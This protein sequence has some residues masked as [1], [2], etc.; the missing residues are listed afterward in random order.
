MEQHGTIGG[1]WVD[2]GRLGVPDL[3][4]PFHRTK[5]GTCCNTIYNNSVD[6]NPSLMQLG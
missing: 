5:N 6:G 2:I 1:K 4:N 3:F